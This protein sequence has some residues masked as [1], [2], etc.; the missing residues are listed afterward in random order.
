MNCDD[1]KKYDSKSLYECSCCRINIC[2]KCYVDDKY[3]LCNSC[4]EKFRIGEICDEDIESWL[5]TCENCGKKWDGNAQ[6][7]CWEYDLRFSSE[8]EHLTDNEDE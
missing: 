1:C 8:S 4:D 3:L 5:V 2:N 6:C 7:N